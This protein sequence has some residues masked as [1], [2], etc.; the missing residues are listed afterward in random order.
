[1]VNKLNDLK[2]ELALFHADG[3]GNQSYQQILNLLKTHQLE[4]KDIFEK[5][6]L[7]DELIGLAQRNPSAVEIALKKNQIDQLKNTLR[8]PAWKLVEQDLSWSEQTQHTLLSCTDKNYPQLL[9]QQENFP[10][11]LYIM[12]NP[13]LLKDMQIAMVGSRTPTPT[14]VENA[15]Q[16]AHYLAINGMVITSGM[17]LGIDAASHR[18]ALAANGKTIAI[19]GTGIDRVYPA[20]HKQLA[21]KIVE[22]GAIVSE[23][24]L[25]TAPLR[26]NFPKR[27]QIISA[28]SVGTLVVEAAL[29][30]GSL[31]TARLAMEQGREVFAIPG[32]IHNPLAKGCHYLIKQGAKLVESA[33]DIIEEIN[34]LC[35]ASSLLQQTEYQIDQQTEQKI[36]KPKNKH[37]NLTISA[38][39]PK[40]QQMILKYLDDNP[41]TIDLLQKRTQ[42]PI[43]ELNSLLV[44]LEI[45]GYIENLPGGKFCINTNST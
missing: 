6:K 28:L 24:P 8:Q 31:I 35:L 16:F 37:S 27:N 11:M 42:I 23:F 26:Q 12:G 38:N 39:L 20:K 33:N 36:V 40:D 13:D 34:P 4:L 44:L 3:I 41:V 25:G 45:Q 19:A 10:M 43:D 32:S 9:Q 17:A 15:Y 1:M 7:F 22:Q 29:K 21:H 5:P 18:G 14:A 2:Y 30:S